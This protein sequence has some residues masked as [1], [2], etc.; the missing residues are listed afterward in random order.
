MSEM[1]YRRLGNSGLKV[2]VVGLGC[3]NFGRRLDA[4]ASAQV[5]H[6]AVDCGITLFDTADVYGSGQSEEY[7]GAAIRD[8]RDRVIIATK[9]ASQMG[10]G[11]MDRGGS[12]GYVRRAVEASLQRLGTDYID[13]YQMHWPDPETPFEETLSV[14]DDLVG[15]GKVRY[16]GCSN[17]AGWQIADA[18]WISRVRGWAPFI[19][20]QNHY[21]MVHRD[22][23]KEVIPACAHF[24]LGMLPFFPLA[25]GV[26]TGKYRRGQEPPEGTR[27]AGNQ[28]SGRFLNDRNLDIVEALERFGQERGVTLL[29]IAIGGLA[30]QPQVASVI[31]GAT[32]PEQVEANVNAGLWE[33]GPEDL[34]EIN[35]IAAA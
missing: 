33:P 6:A 16:I 21:S 12:R 14:L 9:F 7:I 11:P 34:A 26:L 20:A 24:G 18:A 17:Y 27:M 3:N 32:K 35:R 22:V 30:A 15:E 28:N 8:R 25:G 10:D 1:R 23:E 31:A 29:Q 4:A 13:L 5:V 2:S 19:S